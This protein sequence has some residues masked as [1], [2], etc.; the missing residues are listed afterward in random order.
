MPTR[1][2]S[3]LPAALLLWGQSA[4]ADDNGWEF[5]VAPMYLWGKSLDGVSA[6]GGNETPLDLDFRDDI[7]ENL[8]TAFA[9]HVETR[10]DQ[11]TW[12]AEINYARLDPSIVSSMGHITINTDVDYV[13][14]MTEAGV[15]REFARSGRARWEWM[16]GLRYYDQ[17]IDVDLMAAPQNGMASASTT[18]SGGDGWWNGMLG[19]LINLELSSRWTMRL[20]SDLGYGG[21]DNS[22]L[23]A[24]A[25][26]NYRFSDWGSG[27]FGYRFLS[28]DY[29]N[30]KSGA[31]GYRFDAD[32]QGVVLGLNVYF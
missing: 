31:D 32:Q 23:H 25:V 2:W 14:L 27:F 6:M 16:A 30:G 19:L 5:T 24:S 21:S 22:S 1:V 12:F 7:L 28:T 15:F 20:R 10:K 26:A 8:D 9:L 18:I 4:W 29:D 3:A 17:D 11:S 13:D